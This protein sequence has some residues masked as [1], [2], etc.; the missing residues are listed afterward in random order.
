MSDEGYFV[1]PIELNRPPLL[2]YQWTVVARYARPA[3]IKAGPPILCEVSS[4]D[5]SLFVNGER[6]SLGEPVDFLIV[7]S[8]DW[9]RARDRYASRSLAETECERLNRVDAEERG[10]PT[11]T[12]RRERLRSLGKTFWVS[13]GEGHPEFRWPA[14]PG[15]YA[16]EEFSERYS[17]SFWDTVE[18]RDEVEARIL[19]ESVGRVVDLDTGEEIPFTVKVTL[20]D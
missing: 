15:R 4:T 12:T 6:V 19:E 10:D 11:A 20:G 1:Q 7:D 13:Y 18:T 16:L 3:G 17:E 14:R 2:P 8:S 5:V 9:Q